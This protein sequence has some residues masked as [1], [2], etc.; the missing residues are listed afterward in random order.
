MIDKDWLFYSAI[1]FGVLFYVIN[2][3]GSKKNIG[4]A[5]FDSES[6]KQKTDD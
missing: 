6:G 5:R 1:G 4:E 3:F 2:R